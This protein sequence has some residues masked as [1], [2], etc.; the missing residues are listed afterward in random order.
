MTACNRPGCTGL[1]VD[2]YC[3]QCGLRMMGPGEPTVAEATGNES[4]GDAGSFGA[5][6]E[7]AGDPVG[8]AAAAAPG[9]GAVPCPQCGENVV[10]RFCESCGYDVEEGVPAATAAATLTGSADRAHWDRMVGEG[11]PRFPTTP[12]TISFEL[13]GDKVTLGRVRSGAAVDVDLALTG[14]AAD[15]AVSHHQCD[16]VRDNESGSWQVRDT[17]SAN[18]TWLNDA[19]E[20]LASGELHTLADGDRILMGAWTCLTFQEIRHPQRGGEP[21]P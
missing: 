11:E 1:I 18:G 12:P 15:P 2:D 19:T 8:V 7:S 20:P 21:L 5:A 6:P 13:T 17:D 14:P 10:G 9:A 3:D 4:A 16:F